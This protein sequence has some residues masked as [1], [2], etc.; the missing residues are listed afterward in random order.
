MPAKVDMGG[1]FN[2]DGLRV[3][4]TYGENELTDTATKE[5][6][7]TVSELDVNTMGDQTVTVTYEG[8]STTKTVHV[9]GAQNI[10]ITDGLADEVLVGGALNTSGVK[11]TIVYSDKTELAVDA[12][13]LTFG[14]ISTVTAG[15]QTL[16][17]EYLNAKIEKTITVCGVNAIRVEGAPAEVKAGELPDLTDVKI[18]AIYSDK[19]ATMVEVTA[20]VATD[21]VAED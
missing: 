3:T 11:A 16:T 18:Y 1:Q 5:N 19:A 20:E 12:S 6:G 21:E 14:A 4:V 2:T 8:A 13:A 10:I 15:E 7:V 17:I 9:K